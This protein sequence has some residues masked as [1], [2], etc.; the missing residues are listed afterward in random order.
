[1]K[2]QT[3]VLV[4]T[5]FRSARQG[6]R[7]CQ[8]QFTW[9]LDKRLVWTASLFGA[10]AREYRCFWAHRDIEDIRRESVGDCRN[11]VGPGIAFEWPKGAGPRRHCARLACRERGA[12]GQRQP[13]LL[14]A[15]TELALTIGGNRPNANYFLIDGVTNTD[16]TFNTQN[17]S[18]SPNAVQQFQVQAGSYTADM[19][20][21][22]AV[23]STS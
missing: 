6:L 13:T 4:I 20:G 15:K 9:R 8:R 3:S 11:Q 5:A 17:V 21:A 18:L 1:M 16:L 22:G 23:K 7:L 2:W 10:S 19:G 14:E 12:D